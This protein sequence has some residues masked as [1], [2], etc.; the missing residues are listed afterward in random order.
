MLLWA[1]YSGVGVALDHAPS[2]AARLLRHAVLA[3]LLGVAAMSAAAQGGRV[4]LRVPYGSPAELL[5]YTHARSQV[6]HLADG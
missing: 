6:R 4:F 3:C 1:G 5:P 2:H